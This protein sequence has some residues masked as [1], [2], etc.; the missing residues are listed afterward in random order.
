MWRREARSRRQSL[1]LWVAPDVVA[2]GRAG[3]EP[4]VRQVGLVQ[5]APDAAATI[6]V[7]ELLR[8]LALPP[9]S[10]LK[11]IVSDHFTAYAQVPW[12]A[13]MTAASSAEAVAREHLAEVAPELARTGVLQL[14]QAPYGAPRIACVVSR[15]L[16]DGLVQ[17]CHTAHARL[18]CCLPLLSAATVLAPIPSGA[19]SFAV[20]A[21]EGNVLRYVVLQEGL[22]RAIGSEWAASATSESTQ[23]ALRRLALR[24]DEWPEAEC[25]WLLQV[26]AADARAVVRLAL[27]LD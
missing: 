27:E 21:S 22:W 17:A 10:R 14:E 8:D 18:H 13:Q 7:V 20:G 4:Q 12:S 5:E 15:A 25:T 6:A 26:G 3:E 2:C 1:G 11:C 9:G 24:Y 23:S 16:L 19:K